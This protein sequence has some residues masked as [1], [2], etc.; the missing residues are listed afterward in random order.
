MRSERKHS[1]TISLTYYQSL[2]VKVERVMIDKAT[3][4]AA[5]VWQLRRF[6]LEQG[7]PIPVSPAMRRS[8]E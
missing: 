1:S 8:T 6:N 3:R 4:A 5:A 7:R 2:G